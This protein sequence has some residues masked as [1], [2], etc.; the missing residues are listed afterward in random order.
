M[1]GGVNM[2]LMDL[3]LEIRD[4][5]WAKELYDKYYKNKDKINSDFVD[6]NSLIQYIRNASDEELYSIFEDGN[7]AMFI[8]CT[9][10][11]CL[12]NECDNSY[13]RRVLKNVFPHT[14]NKDI[15]IVL[16]IVNRLSKI[17]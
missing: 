3:A 12:L 5:E 11:S 13:K 14:D 8:I 1:N 16:E 10:L 2:D 15:E 4:F 7:E 17:E 9:F 6:I